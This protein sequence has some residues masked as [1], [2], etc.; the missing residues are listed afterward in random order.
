MKDRIQYCSVCDRIVLDWNEET[1]HWT[2]RY[3]DGGEYCI[4]SD[5]ELA[6]AKQKAITC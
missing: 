3:A 2:A 6:L 1:Q 4:C 5:D